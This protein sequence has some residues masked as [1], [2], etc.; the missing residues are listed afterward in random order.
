MNA[1]VDLAAVH[2]EV[3]EHMVTIQYLDNSH[4]EKCQVSSPGLTLAENCIVPT[5]NH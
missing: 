4:I 5:Q 3:S 2:D 1:M